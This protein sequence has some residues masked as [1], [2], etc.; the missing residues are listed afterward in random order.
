MKID[1]TPPVITIN[2]PSSTTYTHSS[3]LTLDY[4]VN[5]GAGSGVASFTP[6][7]DN[8]TLV[9][10]HGLTSGQAINLLTELPIGPHTFTIGSA[11]DVAGNVSNRSVTFTIVVTAD[12]IRADVGQFVASGAITNAKWASSLQAM[13]S[14]AGA[15]RAQGNCTSAANIYLAFIQQ[16]QAQTGKMVTPTAAKIM[17][18][19]AQYLI[20]H[21]P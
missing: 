17:V 6:L 15:A 2:Q 4:T 21:C 20:A 16:L 7:M 12:S 18:A 14:T 3:T 11:T 9:A 8:A 13:L 19:D 5:D 1:V 10:G